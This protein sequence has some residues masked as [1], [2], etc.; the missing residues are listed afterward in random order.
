MHNSLFHNICSFVL[1][2]SASNGYIILYIPVP[3]RQLPLHTRQTCCR[4]FACT[5]TLYV[6]NDY[7]E[8]F[9]FLDAM[10]TF[11]IS[12]PDHPSYYIERHRKKLC[13]NCKL[14]GD[15]VIAL[16]IFYCFFVS[17]LH[18]IIFHHAIWFS[19]FQP[20]RFLGIRIIFIS[21]YLWYCF[22]TFFVRLQTFAIHRNDHIND[23]YVV[24]IKFWSWI[25]NSAPQH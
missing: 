6:C 4:S 14:C 15:L 21:F 3:D 24:F 7:A 11:T 22:Q 18:L 13:W 12:A 10:P 25:S 17:T 23:D 5:Q 8:F 1:R 16:V 20:I 19:I 9:S 2:C